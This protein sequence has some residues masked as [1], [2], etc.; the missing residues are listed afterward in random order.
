M[1]IFGE[2]P[3]IKPQ[4]DTQTSDKR[5]KTMRN[6]RQTYVVLA[7]HLQLVLCLEDCWHDNDVRVTGVFQITVEQLYLDLED[8]RQSK[9]DVAGKVCV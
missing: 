5:F 4:N 2:M 7:E 3:F 6:E 1:H 9:S 8:F